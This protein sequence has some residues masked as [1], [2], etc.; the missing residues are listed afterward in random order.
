MTGTSVKH[1][2]YVTRC[3][4]CVQPYYNSNKK[5]NKRKNG[6]PV[7]RVCNYCYDWSLP[8]SMKS[9]AQILSGKICKDPTSGKK[10]TQLWKNRYRTTKQ[11]QNIQNHDENGYIE[12]TTEVVKE[13]VHVMESSVAGLIHG[14]TEA[15]NSLSLFPKN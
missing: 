13:A 8:K 11:K 2:T 10:F 14:A 6:F 1:A 7:Y 4:I 5:A 12:K 15:L 9:R 3:D